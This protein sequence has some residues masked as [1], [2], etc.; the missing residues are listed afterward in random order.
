MPSF[1]GAWIGLKL[2]VSLSVL[3][4][5]H[6]CDICNAFKPFRKLASIMSEFILL[7]TVSNE[8]KKTL[9]IYSFNEG[10][11]IS[12]RYLILLSLSLLTKKCPFCQYWILL[13]LCSPLLWLTRLAQVLELRVN[14]QKFN[15]LWEFCF[16][17]LPC[18]SYFVKS[19]T[20]VKT[21]LHIAVF[22]KLKSSMAKSVTSN[23]VFSP[24]K[25][26]NQ[27]T[28]KLLLMYRLCNVFIH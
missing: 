1:S 26:K 5:N 10:C 22:K 23:D 6:F 14:N 9:N 7:L 8:L 12:N 15:I 21:N 20:K 19:S 2:I 3:Q 27:V 11:S 16:W 17:I 18:D 4:S 25:Y 13:K 24:S 28:K